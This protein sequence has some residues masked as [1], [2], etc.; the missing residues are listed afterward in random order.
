VSLEFFRKCSV[1]ARGIAKRLI[2]PGDFPGCYLFQE[3]TRAIYV[4]ISRS[5]LGRIRQH[6]RGKTHF[7]AS[8]AYRMAKR[9][10]P[11]RLQR[12]EAMQDAAFQVVFEE[13]QAYLRTLQVSFIPI[14]ND[15]VI[16]LF[17]A[18]CAIELDTADWNTF[19][20]H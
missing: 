8:L 6:L 15:L 5:V 17:E 1:G 4:G 20:T 12:T 18:Y 9:K 14:E 16:Y 11:T 19:R 7:D 10:M 13:C 3:G 2:L